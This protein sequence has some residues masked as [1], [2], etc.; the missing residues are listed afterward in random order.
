MKMVLMLGLAAMLAGGAQA[1]T[2][3]APRNA[4]GQ[5][6][7]SG[8]WTNATLT[9]MTRSPTVG[10]RPVYTPEE[11]KKMEA[12]VAQEVEAAGELAPRAVVAG[13]VHAFAEEQ[14]ADSE[15]LHRKLQQR[16][17]TDVRRHHG[18]YDRG[19]AR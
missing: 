3:K 15:D 18:G 4:M 6:D 17:R 16:G 10:G 13:D 14:V 5:P 1:E 12:A 9:P 19:S 11:V 8:F 2:W 7:L